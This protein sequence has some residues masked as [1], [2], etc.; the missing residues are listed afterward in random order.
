MKQYKTY[1]EEESKTIH[2]LDEKFKELISEYTIQEWEIPTM[3]DEDV[4]VKCG[5][6]KTMPNHLTPVGYINLNDIETVLSSGKIS[7]DNILFKKIYL[8]PAACLHIYPMLE[9]NPVMNQIITIKGH[10]Y[11]YEE[12]GFVEGE[13]QWDFFVREFVAIGEPEYVKGFLNIFQ[14]RILK[15]TEV[16]GLSCRIRA[17]SDP[18]FP[19]KENNLMK[20][21]QKANGL[22]YELVFDNRLAIGSFNYH[23]FHFSKPFHFDQER[24]VVSGCVGFG[25][26]RWVKALKDIKSEYN[27]DMSSMKV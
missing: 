19:T 16:C 12:N 24:K 21:K 20:M 15:L 22:K 26:D 6:F 9:Q 27:G 4:L 7:K 1:L 23:G 14:K 18:F 8:A 11:R 13:R 25:F 10:A 5:Y 3:I 17:A 2:W